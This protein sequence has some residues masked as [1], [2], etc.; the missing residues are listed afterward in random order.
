M[1]RTTIVILLSF[2]LVACATDG[3][4]QKKNFTSTRCGGEIDGLTAVGVKYGDSRLQA[5]SRSD[6]RRRT[7]FRARLKPIINSGDPVNYEN[8]T[9]TI[10]G[11][12]SDPD[13]SWISGSG[14]FSTATD[15]EI[16][17]GCVPGGAPFGKVYAFDIVVDTVGT[18]DPRAEVVR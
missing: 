9:V 16:V 4:P 11:K 8:V 3:R 14:T 18:L 5:R 13:S 6:V 15:H 12:T 10:T 17:L 2:L 7:E 1:K